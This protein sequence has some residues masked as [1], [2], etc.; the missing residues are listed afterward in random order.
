M[1]YSDP[2]V[3]LVKAFESF[4]LQ[5]YLDPVGIPTIG[6][7]HTQGV[8]MG[9]TIT[10]EQADQYLRE[11]LDVAARA[12]NRYSKVSLSQNQFDA[13]TSFVYNVGAGAFQNSTLLRYING[14]EPMNEIH[15]QFMRWIHGDGKV[16]P[17]LVKRRQYEADL[18]TKGF[19]SPL[20]V[21]G[22]LIA[23]YQ[24]LKGP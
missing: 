8:K 7:G 3:N 10:E 22:L 14:R 1:D 5:A 20:V 2:L 23:S 15:A 4:R 11:E 21:M 17:G 19:W 13:L 6:Y 18:F 9:D 16:L 24:A 12:V